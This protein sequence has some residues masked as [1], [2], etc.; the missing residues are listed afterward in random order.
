MKKLAKSAVAAILGRQVKRLYKKNNIKVIGVAGSIG[1]TS[2]KLA[3]AQV[4]SAGFKVRYQEGN[5]NDLVSVP[6]IFFG[7]E[8]PSLY[9]PL[10]WLAVFKRNAKQLKKPYPYDVVVVELGSDAP[11]QIIEFKRYLKLE[12]AVVTAISPEHMQN[13]ASMEDVAKEELSVSQFSS[14]VLANG[15][16]CDTKYLKSLPQFLTYGL[17]KTADYGPSE[18]TDTKDKSEAEQYSLLAA[19]STANKMGMDKDAIKNGLA[20]ISDVPGRMRKLAGINDS[21]IIDDS[22]NA[23]PEAVKLA[24]R[25]FYRLQA[26]QKIGLLGNMNELGETSAA[27]HKEIGELCDPRQLDLVVTLGPDANKYLAPAAEAKGCNVKTFDSPYG[28]GEYIKGQIKKGALILIK[29]SQNGVFAEEAIKSLLANPGDADK[30]VR[31]TPEWL[32]IKQKAFKP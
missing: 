21:I 7:E 5:Y 13:F 20:K 19:V 11:G 4:L 6:L 3:L 32:K 31:Q 17:K 10:A 14:L 27:S 9:N 30:L 18:I 1:K 29:G 2:T 12:I 16:L 22:Y 28:A 8:L 25:Y 23:S 15:D 26:P 24:L